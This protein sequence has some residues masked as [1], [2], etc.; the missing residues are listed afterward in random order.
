M[1]NAIMEDDHILTWRFMLH[2]YLDGMQGLLF[3]DLA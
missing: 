3:G 1:K 2:K